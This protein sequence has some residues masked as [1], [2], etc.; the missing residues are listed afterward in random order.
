MDIENNGFQGKRGKAEGKDEVH[1]KAQR[2]EGSAY[3]GRIRGE[4]ADFTGRV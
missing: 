1:A 3:S 2:C 4:E